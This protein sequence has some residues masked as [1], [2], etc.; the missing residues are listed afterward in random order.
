MMIHELANQSRI[1]RIIKVDLFALQYNG[2]VLTC[3]RKRLRASHQC[4]YRQRR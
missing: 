2:T 4:R 1:T 3:T